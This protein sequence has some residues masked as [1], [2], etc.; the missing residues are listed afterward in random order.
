MSAYTGY[1]KDQNIKSNWFDVFPVGND[2]PGSRHWRD[3][4]EQRDGCAAGWKESDVVY[5]INS[6]GYRGHLTPGDGEPAAFGCSFTYGYGSNQPWPSYL[7][8][9]NCGQPGASN[10]K[11]VRLAVSYCKTFK[12]NCI[13]VMW[14]FPQRREWIDEYG[15]VIAFKNIT[16][17][18][19]QQIMQQ[20]FVSWDNSHLYLMNELWD[21]YNYQKNRLL[22]ENFCIAN[23]IELF[24]T[25]V[26]EIDHRKYPTARDGR[27]PGPDWHMN[28]AA[29]F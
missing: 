25:S 24:Q 20:Q 26:T 6:W 2:A 21:S 7:D 12:P 28:V 14:T 27:H 11:I 23:Q 17:A 10:D 1:N 4:G 18:E 15:N 9:V 8:I 3:P 22:L 5:E 13:Y 19:A 29:L 16:D